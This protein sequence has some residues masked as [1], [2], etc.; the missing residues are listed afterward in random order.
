MRQQ[1]GVTLAITHTVEGYAEAFGNQLR[2][3]RLQPLAGGHD[4]GIQCQ[5]SVGVEAQARH[6]LHRIQERA[7]GCLD[8][9]AEADAAQTAAPPRLLLPRG[10]IVEASVRSRHRHVL[11]ELAGIVGEG[12][13]GAK[14]HLG[15]RDQVAPAQLERGEAGFVRGDVDQALDRVGGFRPAGAAI[16]RRGHDVGEYA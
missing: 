10:E 3:C 4:T 9:I 1:V 14:R 2:Q 7:A 8:A 13:A 6:V 15:R 16:G 12:Q 11:L 5:R